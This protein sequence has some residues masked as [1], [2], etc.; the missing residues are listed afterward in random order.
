M[1]CCLIN[2]GDKSIILVVELCWLLTTVVKE[3]PSVKLEDT[4]LL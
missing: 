4:Q 1:A 2:S 3:P